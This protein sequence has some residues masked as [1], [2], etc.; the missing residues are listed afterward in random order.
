M[1]GGTAGDGARR[2]VSLETRLRSR[3]APS[4]TRPR[5]SSASSFSP[6][7]RPFGGAWPS[8]SPNTCPHL[9][10]AL[11]RGPHRTHFNLP[12]FAQL[13]TC[14]RTVCR[15]CLPALEETSGFYTGAYPGQP[16]E[17]RAPGGARAVLTQRPQ[18]HLLPAP[19]PEAAGS[20]G[21]RRRQALS[22]SGRFFLFVP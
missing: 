17:T 3:V 14:I 19:G 10:T 16:A 20:T 5:G 21:P 4:Q 13:V 11:A 6:N 12:S 8:P 18:A 7:R 2:G 1:F 9:K 22:A 15:E